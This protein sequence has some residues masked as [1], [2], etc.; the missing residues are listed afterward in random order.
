MENWILK[1]RIVLDQMKEEF[2]GTDLTDD[3]FVFG[4][5]F[6]PFEVQTSSLA[7]CVTLFS[8]ILGVSLQ[9]NSI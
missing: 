3:D 4:L 5:L 7:T 2:P 1:N 9:G 6:Q 8:L